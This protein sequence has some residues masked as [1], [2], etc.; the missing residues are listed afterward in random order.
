MIS[1]CPALTAPSI[2]SPKVNATTY[3]TEYNDL[4]ALL[5]EMTIVAVMATAAEM[6]FD[7]ALAFPA[8]EYS[9]CLD[10]CRYR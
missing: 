3:Y 1:S 6:V 5:I 2:F 7:A 10:I 9:V 4:A 8:F